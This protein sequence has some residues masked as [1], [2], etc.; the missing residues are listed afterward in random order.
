MMNDNGIH[1]TE[2][3]QGDDLHQPL[4]EGT[5]YFDASAHMLWMG[6]EIATLKALLQTQ[7]SINTQLINAVKELRERVGVKPS[8]IILPPHMRN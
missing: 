6:R 4:K 1:E 3:P 7:L 2:H 8:P 5:E